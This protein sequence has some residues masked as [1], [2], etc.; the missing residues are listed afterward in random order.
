MFPTR[1]NFQIKIMLK[2]KGQSWIKMTRS[3]QV[4]RQ[5]KNTLPHSSTRQHAV[6]AHTTGHF[7][8][9]FMDLLLHPSNFDGSF[10][11]PFFLLHPSFME[12]HRAVLHNPANT[13]M[14]LYKL[15]TKC[16][17]TILFSVYIWQPQSG[18]G[19]VDTCLG[20]TG[21]RREAQM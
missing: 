4:S 1:L 10:L 21:P 6:T 18:Q 14:L 19:L 16:D 11:G 5:D 9:K 12:I 7:E 13:N 3:Q 8:L 2:I 20:T 15:S 17:I